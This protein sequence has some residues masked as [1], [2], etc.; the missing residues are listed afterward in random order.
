MSLNLASAVPSARN[1]FSI[2]RVQESPSLGIS[3]DSPL[4]RAPT[5][6]TPCTHPCRQGA[7][8]TCVQLCPFLCSSPTPQCLSKGCSGKSGDFGGLGKICNKSRG[9]WGPP[10]ERF[11]TLAVWW[12]LPAGSRALLERFTTVYFADGV[13]EA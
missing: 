13:A 10:K 6:D 7:V 9:C 1:A 8:G 3:P 2:N 5:S 11:I 4:G 12:A